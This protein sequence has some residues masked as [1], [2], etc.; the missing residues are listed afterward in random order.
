METKQIEIKNYKT[1]YVAMD[2]TEFDDANECRTYDSSALGVIKG[3]LA[4]MATW[5]G[6]E[7]DLYGGAGSDENDTFV[8]VPKTDAEVM[9]VQQAMFASHDGNKDRQQKNADRVVLGRPVA[10]TF[11]YNDEYTW[12]TALDEII[13][14]ATAGKFKLVENEEEGK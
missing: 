8:V 13:K 11:S 2:G 4:K 10:V 5:H 14:V 12:T 9:M 6:S 1:V 3:R 7:C